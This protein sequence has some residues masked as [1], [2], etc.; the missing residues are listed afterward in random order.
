MDRKDVAAALEEVAVLLE[1]KGENPFK[2]RAYTQAA[3][4][5]SSLEVDLG[6]LAAQ[7]V[8]TRSRGLARVWLPRS[9]NWWRRA[10]LGT[11]K[12]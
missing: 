9:R 3:R 12:N 6:E 7:A 1:L 10:G 2:I 11:P 5:I 8:W 4:T